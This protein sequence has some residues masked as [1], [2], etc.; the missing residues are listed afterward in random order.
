MW[1]AIDGKDGTQSSPLSFI[2]LSLSLFAQ[3]KQM[4]LPWWKIHILTVLILTGIN[5]YL[6]MKW[7][8]S[9][10]SPGPGDCDR[11]MRSAEGTEPEEG[12]W[13]KSLTA[14]EPSF[15]ADEEG[16]EE[17]P[18]QMFPPRDEHEH[19]LLRPGRRDN[20]REFV[21]RDYAWTGRLFQSTA[22]NQDVCL[23]TQSSLDRL[24][25]LGQT[26][27]HWRGAISVAVYLADEEEA[28]I[29]QRVLSHL[30]RCHP[31]LLSYVAFHTVSSASITAV[32]SRST[33]ASSTSSSSSASMGDES[34]TRRGE[35]LAGNCTGGPSSSLDWLKRMRTSTSGS[36]SSSSLS[37]KWATASRPYPQNLMRNVARKACPS[38]YVF[39][40][41]VDVIPSFNMAES[42]AAF[43]DSP[44]VAHCLKCA[45][46]V[47]TYELDTRAG[48]PQNK[49]QLV[50]LE[51]QKLAQPFHQKA[52]RY[53]QFASNL[54]R[55]FALIQVPLFYRHRQHPAGRL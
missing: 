33:T 18:P 24:H 29:F 40:V 32:M 52:F 39:L 38:Q 13:R 47:P 21:I 22:V 3:S 49:S 43:L 35:S 7:I 23:A 54:T 19:V 34:A 10:G 37:A 12:A 51:D 27:D 25:W 11:A 17:L 6:L 41:D 14:E 28:A 5:I 9:S 53:N 4:R 55:F 44:A 8:R 30:G 20:S 46:V 45:F 15:R 1:W 36:S 16:A 50:Q 2:S 42:L 31:E 48:F 26:A